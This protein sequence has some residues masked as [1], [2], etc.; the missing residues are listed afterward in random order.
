MQ[1]NYDGF[2]FNCSIN[3]AIRTIHLSSSTVVSSDGYS[4]HMIKQVRLSNSY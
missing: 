2:T 1:A 4:Y 3:D